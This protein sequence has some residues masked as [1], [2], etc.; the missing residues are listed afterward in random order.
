MKSLPA[1]AERMRGIVRVLV[2]AVLAVMVAVAGTAPG[3]EPPKDIGHLWRIARPGHADSYL[4]GTIHVADSRVATLA[5]PVREALSRSRTLAVEIVPES[6]DTRA[7]ELELLEADGALAPMLRPEVF[8]KLR[9]ELATQGLPGSVIERLKPWAAMMKLGR[10]NAGPPQA[11]NLDARLLEV[12]RELR[13][14]VL[15]LEMLDEQIS[16]F[17]TIPLASQ[18]ALLEHAVLHRDALAATVEPTILAWQRGDFRALAP[19][20]GVAYDSFP[21]MGQH[22]AHLMTHII[23]HRTVLML[24]RLHEPL[25]GGR[26]F[27]AVGAM[28]LPGPRGL[29]ALLRAEGYVLTPVW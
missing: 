21:G 1:T 20:A 2:L 14:K 23:D 3:R 4:F 24:H 19:I 16:A 6:A 25:R 13:L 8:A 9:A 22:R 15:P 12:A 28:H 11:Q 10:S 5:P 18:V 26:L 27:V 7:T 29:L 17:D